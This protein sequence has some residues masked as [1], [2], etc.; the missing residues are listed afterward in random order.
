MKVSTRGELANWIRRQLGEPVVDVILDASQLDDSIDE[1]I[2]YFTEHAGGVGHEEQYV[3][4][5]QAQRYTELQSL[6]TLSE[7]L[8]A[9][10]TGAEYI[11]YRAEY[12]LPCNVLAISPHPLE[13]SPYGFGGGSTIWTSDGSINTCAD[14]VAANQR[15]QYWLRTGMNVA[16]T[17]GSPLFGG[18]PNT[19]APGGLFFPGVGYSGYFSGY[20]L[21]GT[22]GGHRSQGGGV[23]LIT[24]ELGLQYLEMI[25]QRYS[26]RVM[27]QFMEQQRKVR[28]SPKPCGSGIFVLPVW[29]R[30]EDEYL[31]DNIWIRR[32]AMALAQRTIGYNTKKYSGAQFP[33]GVQIDGDFYFQEGNRMIELLEKEISDNK[34]NY[35]PDFY[36]G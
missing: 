23:D 3:A 19:F 9:S 32:Y 5:I 12:Q 29:A 27:A 1:A 11:T 25:K 35:P 33:G 15:D 22:R 8:S 24:Y 10:S 34:Y 36:L 26:I 30:V 4:I 21:Y 14:A 18:T 20:S 2:Q 28:F 7:K 31:Y 13:N 16:Q 17:F 6:P